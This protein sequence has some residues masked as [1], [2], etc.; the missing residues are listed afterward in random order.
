MTPLA[1]SAARR[2]ARAALTAYVALGSAVAVLCG[3]APAAPTPTREVPGAPATNASENVSRHDAAAALGSRL[4]PSVEGQV[5]LAPGEHLALR[6]A[7]PNPDGSTGIRYD[8][9]YQ[10]LPVLGEQVIVSAAADSSLTVI[11]EPQVT[12]ENI[13]SVEPV[14]TASAAAD[15]AA[16]SQ[17]SVPVTSH[18]EQLVVDA[19]TSPAALAWAVTSSTGEGSRA[20]DVALTVVDAVSGSV[21]REERL[22]NEGDG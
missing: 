20:E 22:M 18:R 19:M 8:R 10:G 9:T 5:H 21:R 11:G 12:L 13:V 3:C 15:R 16:S 4:L 2:P 17:T 7:F 14:I 6:D 1:A